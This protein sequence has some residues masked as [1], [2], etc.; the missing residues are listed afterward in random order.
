MVGQNWQDKTPLEMTIVYVVV[1]PKGKEPKEI[2][3]PRKVSR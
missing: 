2:L 3:V 1:Y